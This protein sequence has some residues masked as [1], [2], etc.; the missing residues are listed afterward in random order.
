MIIEKN[1]YVIK[2]IR[3]NEFIASS[4]DFS[5][6]TTTEIDRAEFFE[7]K[8][9]AEM[10]IEEYI[11]EQYI[12]DFDIYYTEVTYWIDDDDED[13]D[14]IYELINT[15]I[16][17][18]KM[19]EDAIIPS[20]TI[21]NVGYDI[22]ACFP[23]NQ[24]KIEPHETKL[25]P[26]GIASIIPDGYAMILKDRGSTGS[27]GLSTAC[28]VIDSNFRGEWFVAIHNENDFPVYIIKDNVEAPEGKCICYPYKK[29]ITQA[30]LIEDINAIVEEIDKSVLEVN[31]TDRGTGTLG[32]S[33]K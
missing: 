21:G 16:Q 15:K 31:V 8:E 5:Y 32:S 29:A 25:I 2:D 3:E 27:K 19:R 6:D 1:G 9:D 26:T 4:N 11:E 23:D 33:G 30:I 18:A 28:G 7:N 10:Y 14:D 24:I 20:K 12:P 22:Y 17:F 13:E